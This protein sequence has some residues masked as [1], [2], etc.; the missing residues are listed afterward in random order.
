MSPERSFSNGNWIKAS[1]TIV[2]KISPRIV[3]NR[4][5]VMNC[6][7]IFFLMIS[8][9]VSLPAYLYVGLIFL[10][11]FCEASG[12]GMFLAVEV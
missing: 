4:S 7:G 12:V 2:K 6:F 10:I 8:L 11:G 1:T 5:V 3:A 9:R